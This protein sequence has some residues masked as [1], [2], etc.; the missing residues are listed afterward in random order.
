[1]DSPTSVDAVFNIPYRIG[2]YDN[3]EYFI[4]FIEPIKL[5]F[6]LNGTTKN[7]EET[8]NYF[9]RRGLV[10]RIPQE[11]EEIENEFYFGVRLWLH[12]KNIDLQLFLDQFIQDSFIPKNGR[13]VMKNHIDPVVLARHPKLSHDQ[14]STAAVYSV[15][16]DKNYHHV[17]YSGIKFQKGWWRYDDNPIHPR[18]LW[19]FTYLIKGGAWRVFLLS[20]VMR[21][22]FAR[23][24]RK[25]KRLKYSNPYRTVWE[26][27]DEVKCS[28][29][30]M[31][32]LRLQVICVPWIHRL[33]EKLASK[34]KHFGSVLGIEKFYFYHDPEHPIVKKIL[35]LER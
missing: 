17:L 19:F 20:L 24:R 7:R 26:L 31:W 12:T 14:M 30:Y 11:P 2:K 21:F 6:F 1:V 29:A 5:F 34:N 35:E 4:C 23:E 3:T 13:V 25:K 15:L 22:T 28:E 27:Q 18:D 32:G 10:K 8:M 16:R 33:Y 9:T